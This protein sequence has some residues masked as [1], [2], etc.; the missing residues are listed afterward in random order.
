MPFNQR[1]NDIANKWNEAF[2]PLIENEFIHPMKITSNTLPA[3]F[4]YPV[5]CKNNQIRLDLQ[6]HLEKKGVETRPIVCG[7]LVRQP[8][9]K[10]LTYRVAKDL[11]GA[12]RVMNAGLYWGLHPTTSDH[13]IDHLIHTV[14][15]FFNG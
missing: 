7:N 2:R 6:N 14:K 10:H 4:G 11:S 3:F 13:Q 1:R 15:E 5:L 8:A 12:D 9:L